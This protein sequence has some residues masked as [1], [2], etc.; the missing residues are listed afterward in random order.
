MKLPLSWLW[1]GEATAETDTDRDGF[2]SYSKE[3][4]AASSGFRMGLYGR[5]PN[6]QLPHS[7]AEKRY[8]YWG[9]A[10]GQFL[11]FLSGVVIMFIGG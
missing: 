10:F 8:F 7:K 6:P 2:M 11:I 1:Q 4:H 9:H 5:E 3:W